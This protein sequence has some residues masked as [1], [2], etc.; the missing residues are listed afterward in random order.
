MA[1]I[2]NFNSKQYD[3]LSIIKEY[4]L[5]DFKDWTYEQRIFN[6]ATGES[7]TIVSGPADELLAAV[8]QAAKWLDDEDPDAIDNMYNVIEEYVPNELRR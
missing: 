1:D 2:I 4:E 8:I 6:P 7:L 3:M 5:E